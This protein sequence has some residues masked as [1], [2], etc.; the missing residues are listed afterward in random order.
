MRTANLIL[1]LY[2]AACTTSNKQCCVDGATPTADG[3]PCANCG[4]AGGQPG[5]DGGSGGSPD[6]AGLLFT[7]C[8]ELRAADPSLRDGDFKLYVGR[9]PGKPWTAYCYD[10]AGIPREF[11]TVAAETNFGG[12]SNQGG[13]TVM[14]GVQSNYQKLRVDPST[15]MVDV[16]DRTF[17]TSKG[18]AGQPSGGSFKTVTTMALGTAM[19][20]SNGA[21]KGRASVDLTGT[22]FTAK[23]TDFVQD[24]YSPTGSATQSGQ[25]VTVTG[26]GYCG[27]VGPGAFANGDPSQDGGGF[28]LQLTYL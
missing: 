23:S 1:C 20:C 9:D 12:F 5:V 22:P 17:A 3:A 11:L 8:A 21:N 13:G 4:D 24:G 25:V 18:Q 2:L 19:D 26:G 15:L 16:A 6:L 10:M 28:Q 27:W 14:A 7:S